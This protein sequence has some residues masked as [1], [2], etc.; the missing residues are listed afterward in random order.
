MHGHY[1]SG[2][3]REQEKDKGIHSNSSHT[4]HTW[5]ILAVLM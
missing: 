4:F 1:R 5:D 3:D 2:K